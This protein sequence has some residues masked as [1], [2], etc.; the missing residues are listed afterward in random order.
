MKP[1]LIQNLVKKRR[2]EVMKDE[3]LGRDIENAAN[4]MVSIIF[5]I[6]AILVIGSIILGA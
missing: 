4:T 2:K 3:P 1:V 5:V 6:L